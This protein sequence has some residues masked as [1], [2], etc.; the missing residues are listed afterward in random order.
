MPPT[1]VSLFQATNTK[2]L[3]HHQT[4]GLTRPPEKSQAAHQ[5]LH[6]R[7]HPLANDF[8]SDDA[9]DQMSTL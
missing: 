9:F 3:T 2:P 6:A 8:V 1:S 5:Q 7:D 4:G